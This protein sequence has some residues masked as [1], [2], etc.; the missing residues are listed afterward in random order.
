MSAHCH[1][2]VHPL[3]TK[4]SHK[5]LNLAVRIS[6][7]HPGM[8]VEA[9]SWRLSGDEGLSF[10]LLLSCL[11]AWLLVSDPLQLHQI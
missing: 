7:A 5:E 4:L 10:P 9:H 6:L 11:L 2:P 8:E 3:W 1:P